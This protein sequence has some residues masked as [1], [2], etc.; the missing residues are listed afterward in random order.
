MLS[1][2]GLVPNGHFLDVP[3]AV[4]GAVYYT[5]ILIFAGS[6]MPAALTKAVCCGA[7]ASSIFLAYQLTFV[8]KELCVLCWST[9]VINTILFYRLILSKSPSK[10]GEVKSNNKK[11]KEA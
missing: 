9:H 11:T 5:Y 2:F 4:L 8:I 1:Y 7:M 10:S 3:N 6:I